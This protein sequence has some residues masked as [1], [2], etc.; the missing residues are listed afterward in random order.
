M[1][2]ALGCTLSTPTLTHRLQHNAP[3]PYATM[4][5]IEYNLHSEE[6]GRRSRNNVAHCISAHG[7]Y[8]CG[9]RQEK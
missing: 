6:Y 2:S 3:P 4:I 7:E 8:V 1:R 5:G 9:D